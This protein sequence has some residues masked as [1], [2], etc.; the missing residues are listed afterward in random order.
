MM[1]ISGTFLQGNADK[2]SEY[3]QERDLTTLKNVGALTPAQKTI[4]ERA[5]TVGYGNANGIVTTYEVDQ[6]WQPA[7][8][9]TLSPVEKNTLAQVWEKFRVR[10]PNRVWPEYPDPT[11]M[12][13]APTNQIAATQRTIAS[14]PASLRAIAQRVQLSQDEDGKPNTVSFRDV[15][16]AKLTNAYTPAEQKDLADLSTWF[17]S[18]VLT[19]P[20]RE[21]T[22]VDIPKLGRKSME[23]HDVAGCKVYSNYEDKLIY[24]QSRNVLDNDR[25]EGTLLLDRQSVGLTM[26][27]PTGYKVIAIGDYGQ[28]VFTTSPVLLPASRDEHLVEIYDPNGTKVGD[29]KV[30]DSF[31]SNVFG[32]PQPISPALYPEITDGAGKKFEPQLE[33]FDTTVA[34]VTG[35]EKYVAEWSYVPSGTATHHADVAAAKQAFAIDAGTLKNGTY[36]MPLSKPGLSPFNGMTC[37]LSKYPGPVFV[38]TI[39]GV[40][41]V[42]YPNGRNTASVQ[43]WNNVFRGVTPSPVVSMNGEKYMFKVQF[44]PKTNK[45]GIASVQPYAPSWGFDVGDQFLE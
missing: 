4:L 41:T 16:R 11:P 42:L 30:F 3:L 24:R 26:T 31:A 9:S 15:A 25:S 33:S 20:A 39:A 40:Q 43:S 14:L 34:Y 23:F 37:V 22:L 18:N 21:Q 35:R 29:A 32:F 28:R 38:V 8:H 17:E 27:I 10:N 36:T 6:L 19:I 7:L 5:D 45:L 1:T 13:S 12:V 44:D 2:N